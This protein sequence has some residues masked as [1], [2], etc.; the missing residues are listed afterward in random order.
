MGAGASLYMISVEPAGTLEKSTTK[1]ARTADGSIKARLVMPFNCGVAEGEVRLTPA[2]ETSYRIAGSRD[3]ATPPAMS[4]RI[5]QGIPGATLRSLDAGEPFA[6]GKEFR[7]EAKLKEGIN[8][9]DAKKVT[10]LIRDDG[11]VLGDEVP[12]AAFVVFGDDPVFTEF[13]ADWVSRFGPAVSA[14]ERAHGELGAEGERLHARGHHWRLRTHRC[15]YHAVAG[16]Q[17]RS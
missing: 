12:G 13:A 11:G 1:S 17:D 4:Q 15:Q 3:E 10:K 14:Y 9:E 6:S 8:Q 16:G 5:A 2:P 7:I